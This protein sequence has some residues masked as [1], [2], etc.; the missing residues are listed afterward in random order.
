MKFKKA[1]RLFDEYN[2][3]WADH[4]VYSHGI[5]VMKHATKV[6]EELNIDKYQTID[7]EL[8][9]KYHDIGK[10]KCPPHLLE[11]DL[12]FTK[13][14]IKTFK[15]HAKYGYDILKSFYGDDSIA[16]LVLYHHEKIDGSGYL[17]GLKGDKIPL[18]SRIIT[19]CDA[20]DAMFRH[21]CQRTKEEAIQELKKFKGKHFDEKIVDIFLK[22][23]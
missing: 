14:D 18:G 2:T 23:I 9:A 6:C 21:Y 20:Y 16:N 4:H 15:K 3:D 12:K 10:V 17:K 22:T 5:R 13:K 1:K 11:G 8:A 7:I 19:V